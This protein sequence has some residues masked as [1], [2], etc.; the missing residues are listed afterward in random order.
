[1]SHTYIVT[2]TSRPKKNKIERKLFIYETDSDITFVKIL[3]THH[4][5]YDMLMGDI[6]DIQVYYNDIEDPDEYYEHF[7]SLIK[8]KKYDEIYSEL[9]SHNCNQNVD[10][11]IGYSTIRF[12]DKDDIS[13]LNEQDPRIVM[14]EKNYYRQYNNLLLHYF[15]KCEDQKIPLFDRNCFKLIK[16]YLH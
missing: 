7:E 11:E 15:E 14:I 5:V 3:L 2:I 9:E 1:M 13:I 8:S 12:E 6:A 10:P 16:T 4:N